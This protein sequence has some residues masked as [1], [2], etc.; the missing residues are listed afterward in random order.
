MLVCDHR[1]GTLALFGESKKETHPPEAIDDFKSILIIAYEQALEEGIN[2]V[3]ALTAV[4]EWA[5]LEIRR[6]T[7]LNADG[8][9]RGSSSNGEN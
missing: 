5:S 7:G 9:K 3:A 8:A 4:L 2:P 6:C 1:L